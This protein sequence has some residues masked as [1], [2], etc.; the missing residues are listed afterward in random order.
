MLPFTPMTL[1]PA[2]QDIIAKTL[3]AVI[4]TGLGYIAKVIFKV[5]QSVSIIPDMKLDLDS[6]HKKIRDIEKRISMQCDD[7][8]QSNNNP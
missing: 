6:A 7:T 1:G 4:V 3:Q 5:V 8:K 2:E